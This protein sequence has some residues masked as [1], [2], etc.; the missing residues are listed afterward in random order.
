MNWRLIATGLTLFILM[1]FLWRVKLD[2]DFTS[3][4]DITWPHV[5]YLWGFASNLMKYED[6]LNLWHFWKQ[7]IRKEY[8]KLISLLNCCFRKVMFNADG[9]FTSSLRIQLGLNLGFFAD[10]EFRYKS[11]FVA[12]ISWNKGGC[13]RARTRAAKEPKCS[14]YPLHTAK[15][16]KKV[17]KQMRDK[18]R[19]KQ[20]VHLHML[21]AFCCH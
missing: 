12:C 3:N 15:F 21:I 6:G 17:D 7:I 18:I 1:L 4:D 13:A 20:Q 10:V 8:G 14:A 2:V 19:V 9:F 16:L 11:V 5:R